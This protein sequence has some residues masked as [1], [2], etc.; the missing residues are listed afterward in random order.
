M[1][2]W[3]QAEVE[4][5]PR[6]AVREDS[7][8]ARV[9]RKG[10]TMTDHAIIH[11]EICRLKAET[12]L[13][14]DQKRWEDFASFFTEDALIDYSRAAPPGVEAPPPFRS[15]AAYAQFAGAFVGEARTVHLA[16]LPIIKVLAPDRATGVWKMEDIIIWPEGSGQPSRHGYATYEDEYQLT[17][18]GWRIS[19]LRFTPLLSVSIDAV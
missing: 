1:V 6:P 15:G 8:G 16:S 10:E 4:R 14:V 5:R 11:A 7:G 3:W 13:A 17:A 2:F 18:N 12:L 9:V 19:A